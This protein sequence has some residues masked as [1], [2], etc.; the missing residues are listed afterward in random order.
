MTAST[1]PARGSDAPTVYPYEYAI[2][3][4][5]AAW[6]LAYAR[7]RD[8]RATIAA[9]VY[10]AVMDALSDDSPRVCVDCGD[11]GHPSCACHCGHPDCGA[12]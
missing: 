7:E 6:S 5:C 4:A 11:E 10:D 2:D 1:S 12:C 9:R 8:D 3:A